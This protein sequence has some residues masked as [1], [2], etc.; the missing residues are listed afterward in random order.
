MTLIA[1]MFVFA[2]W[3]V[4][5]MA[6]LPSPHAL[7]W[8][9]LAASLVFFAACRYAWAGHLKTCLLGLGAFLLGFCWTSSL[10]L[11][12][13]SD[14]LPPVW[15]QK[16][17]E[18]IGVVASV[19]EVTERGLRFRFDVE[20]VLTKAAIVPR[21]ISLNY[22]AN[23]PYHDR[24]DKNSSTQV[25]TASTSPNPFHAGQR[26]QLSVRLKRP[27][28]ASNPHGF[29]F[30]AWALSESI[31]A[32]GSVKS[33][34]GMRKLTD[35]VWQ[36]GYVIER[37]RELVGQRIV[38]VLAERP[39]SGI[40]LALV[41]GDDSQIKADDWQVFLRTGTSHL[42]SISGLHIT[43]L[44]GL[45]FAVASFIWRR[46]PQC[47]MFLPTRKA[48]TMAGVMAALAYALLAGFSVPTQRTFYM[49]LVLAMAL[50]SG[51]QLGVTQVL[52][53]ALWVVVALDPWAVNAP[54]FY[55]SFAA[56]AIMAYALNGGIAQLSW[57]KAALKTQWA[58]TIGMLPAVLI[59]FN[60]TSIVS[61]IANAIAI[62]LISFIVTP[63]ALL[64]SFLPMDG[65]LYLAYAALD[66]C[67]HLL[68]GLNSWPVST[69]QQQAPATWTLLPALVGVLW[70]L[71]P[72]GFPMRYLGLLMFLPMLSPLPAR[73]LLGDMK[74]TVLDV[75]QGL[76]VVVQT[77]KHTLLYDAGPKY[78]SQ[79][80]AG[81]RIVV[82]YLRG[83]GVAKLDGFVVSHNDI[84][85]S[86]GM[87]AVMNLMPVTWLASS[88][89]AVV[90]VSTVPQRL[91]CFAGQTWTWD[92]VRFDMLY[93]SMTSY[94]YADIKDNNRSCVL[95]VSS[96]SGSLLL[97]GDVEQMGERALLDAAKDVLSSDVLL[98]PHH[99]S[100]TSS[101][102]DF[103][104]A[105]G[106][107]ISIFTVGYLNHYQHPNPEVWARHLAL[108]GFLYRSDYAGAVEMHFTQDSET[109][110]G[111]I[112]LRP[113]RSQYRRYWHDDY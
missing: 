77:A 47:V 52:T 3:V 40:I 93:P 71:L 28:G 64:G 95:K 76:S 106:P 41:M 75:G 49:L 62:P 1:L 51:R 84:D 25:S 110:S 31:R 111:N 46:N 20:S 79:S 14:A 13:M 105:V 33:K 57:Y 37:V 102:V 72:S 81:S 87:Q 38:R 109:R 113:W 100:R 83:I 63:L 34:A 50:W 74:V 73:P 24:K 29:D 108:G 21:H 23:N 22:Y 15:Q 65:L 59:L 18:V 7:L 42:M 101:G 103:I 70:L 90:D 35:F 107:T 8:L 26:W 94:A 86:G 78:D 60:Q 43:M 2:A 69:W 97:T 19:P 91:T 10:A 67:M 17:I 12:R 54:G 45:A 88:L 56:V 98:V 68:H 30:E 48:A 112:H 89:P 27:H 99:G 85:H 66:G 4:Q 92:G 61:P 53:V 44:A 39:Y 9:A 104:E 36:P 80:D 96:Q 32:S 6:Q 55:L 58:V 82:P 5:Q 16:T 11:W